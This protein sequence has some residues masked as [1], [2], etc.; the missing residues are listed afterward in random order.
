MFLELTTFPLLKKLSPDMSDFSYY[1]WG[2]LLFKSKVDPWIVN[3]IYSEAKKLNMHEHE[4]R[5]SLAGA[6]E[7]ELGFSDDYSQKIFNMILPHFEGYMEFCTE[8]WTRERVPENT[9]F[10]I[11]PVKTW[12]N[13]Q[14][15]MEYNP[16]HTHTGELSFVLYL[17]IPEVL[18]WESDPRK[19]LQPGMIGFYY[20][21]N[22][23]SSSNHILNP[24]SAQSFRPETGD[25]FIFPAYLDHE[26]A[27]FKSD[28]VRVSMSG[29]VRVNAILPEEQNG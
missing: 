25:I 21:P 8:S 22:M 5:S 23:I 28:V 1:Y 24:I 3:E 9:K 16:R 15:K 7:K 4:V 6:I 20:P 13:F 18:Q 27:A 10:E 12:V 19:S 14:E 29:N 2:P 26:V 11:Q 17:D